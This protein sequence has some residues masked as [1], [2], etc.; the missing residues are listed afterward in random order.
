MLRREQKGWLGI[1]LGTATVKVAQLARAEGRTRVLAT[2]QVPRSV[3][4]QEEGE[5]NDEH[6]WSAA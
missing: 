6:L 3:H 1:D 5:G 4:P 2:A